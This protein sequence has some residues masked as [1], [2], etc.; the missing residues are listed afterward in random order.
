MGVEPFLV[1]SSLL[2][3]LAQRLVRKLC[4]ECKEVYT[5]TDSELHDLGVLRQTLAGIPVY[6]GKGCDDCHKKGYSGRA[7]LL[8]ALAITPKIKELIL[9]GAQEY[10]IK[11]LGRK[12]GMKTLRDNG[13]A[14]ILA[15]VT[16]PE[17]VM[18]VT[19]RDEDTV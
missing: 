10:E 9:R 3:V 11:A 17:E 14:K 2:M 18:R 16:T 8:E 12:E 13:I 15:G 6:R 7:V 4:P 19:V 5:P 1:S